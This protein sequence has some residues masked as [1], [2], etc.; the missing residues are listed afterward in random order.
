[1]FHACVDETKI[2]EFH[3]AGSAA[4][5]TTAIDAAA[6]DYF[7]VTGIRWHRWAYVLLRHTTFPAAVP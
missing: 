7:Y 5:R 4:P 1:M 3:G 6:R 2:G